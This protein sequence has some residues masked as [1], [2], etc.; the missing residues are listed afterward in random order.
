MEVSKRAILVVE[1]DAESREALCRTLQA[2]FE[3]YAAGDAGEALELLRQR[4]VHVIVAGQR[5]PETTGMALLDCVQRQWPATIRVALAGYCDLKAVIEA[6]EPVGLFG[7][8]TK[9]CDADEAR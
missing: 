8:L 7:Y 9:P 4:S 3:V 2:E 5:L 6:S 1:G